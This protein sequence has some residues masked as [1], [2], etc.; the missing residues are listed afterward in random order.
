MWQLQH[1]FGSCSPGNSGQKTDWQVPVSIS[2]F[3]FARTFSA[4]ELFALS[5]GNAFNVRHVPSSL[6][7]RWAAQLRICKAGCWCDI[8]EPGRRS[9]HCDPSAEWGLPPAFLPY[10]LPKKGHFGTSNFL[11][12]IVLF[13]DVDFVLLLSIAFTQCPPSS[14]FKPNVSIFDCRQ[15]IPGAFGGRFLE[16]GRNC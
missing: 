4:Q 11:L 6:I 16:F 9:C 1:H 7:A 12:F 5:H 2:R 3:Q 14:H 10:A 13:V 15:F 8:C